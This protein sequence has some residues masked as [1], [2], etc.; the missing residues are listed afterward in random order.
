MANPRA[1]SACNLLHISSHTLCGVRRHR[2]H[3]FFV[4]TEDF[5]MSRIRGWCEPADSDTSRIW[6]TESLPG[7]PI[8]A[9]PPRSLGLRVRDPAPPAAGSANPLVVEAFDELV[10]SRVVT[11]L[12]TAGVRAREGCFVC[13]FAVG[14]F[15]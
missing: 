11:V 2:F 1:H 5:C 10:Q 12:A 9:I 4:R 7:R 6:D 15:V 14:G 3:I 8:R 13:H